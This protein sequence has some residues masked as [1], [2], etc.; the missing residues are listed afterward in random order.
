MDLTSDK[1]HTPCPHPYLAVP[2]PK[3]IVNENGTQG[4]CCHEPASFSTIVCMRY[5]ILQI[6]SP[7]CEHL[8]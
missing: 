2:K 7:D 8:N 4:T 5:V 3:H 6:G 1:E